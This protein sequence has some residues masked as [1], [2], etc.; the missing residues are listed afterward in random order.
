MMD[1][2]PIAGTHPWEEAAVLP[3][4]QHDGHRGHRGH[5]MGSHWMFNG[6]SPEAISETSRA[7]CFKDSRAEIASFD[8]SRG[9]F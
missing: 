2:Q 6:S 9:V 7:G 3:N 8:A 1:L 4:N 5:W